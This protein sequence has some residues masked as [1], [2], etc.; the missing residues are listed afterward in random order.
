MDILKFCFV[1]IATLILDLSAAWSQEK[2]ADTSASQ[3]LSKRVNAIIWDYLAPNENII[4]NDTVT[5]YTFAFVIDVERVSPYRC[6]ARSVH[7]NDS[8]AYD[9]FKNKD[10]SFLKMFDY[11]SVLGNRKSARIILPC[12]IKFD[13]PKKRKEETLSAK[14]IFFYDFDRLINPMFN[15]VNM[16]IPVNDY[17]YLPP[18]FS[19]I[20][21]AY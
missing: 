1:F 16:S 2:Q 17:I 7:L 10:V 8:V 9:L 3:R 14:S 11:C 5:I 21:I 15:A 18:V 12:L 20:R 13:G 4:N 19:A 6:N